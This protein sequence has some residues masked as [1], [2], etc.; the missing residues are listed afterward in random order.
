MLISIVTLCVES[1]RVS[2][3]D[4][5]KMWSHLRDTCRV[6]NAFNYRALL[7]GLQLTT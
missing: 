1:F 6:A 4:F 2:K 7:N 5:I 3:V